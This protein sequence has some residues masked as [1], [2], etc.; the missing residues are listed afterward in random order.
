MPTSADDE[1]EFVRYWYAAERRAVRRYRSTAAD[2]GAQQQRRRSTALSS[3][4]GQCRVD[5]RVDEPEHRLV[6]FATVL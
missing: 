6:R 1:T 3:K 2:A 5:S 4:C